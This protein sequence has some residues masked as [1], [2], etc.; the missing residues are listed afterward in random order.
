M[1]PSPLGAGTRN[2]A[3]TSWT[4]TTSAHPP[5]RSE[6]RSSS[7]DQRSATPARYADGIRRSPP[8][9][10]A[11]E[12][13][14]FGNVLDAATNACVNGAAVQVVGDARP[15]SHAE[16]QCGQPFNT[17]PDGAAGIVV[18]VKQVLSQRS[19]SLFS[20]ELAQN[21]FKRQNLQRALL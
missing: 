17:P 14:I 11:E 6:L 20:S 9:A 10:P 16:N 2:S 19:C 3:S 21:T 8:A 5:T 1:R 12:V 13:W 7:P 18:A 4:G 15:N